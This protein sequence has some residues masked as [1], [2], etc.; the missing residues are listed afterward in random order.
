MSKKKFWETID[1]KLEREFNPSETLQWLKSNMSIYW[2]W[3]VAR[4]FKHQDKALFLKVNG[5]IHKGWVMITLGWNDT[6][7]VRLLN[8]QYNEIS[9][10][11]DI[12]CDVLQSFIDEKVEKQSNYTF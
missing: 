11:T 4:L 6:Y 9:V 1:T 8:N 5:M 12:Y 7:T 3:G 2:S 10:D